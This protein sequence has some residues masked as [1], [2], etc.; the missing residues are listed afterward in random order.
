MIYG[1]P[2][3]DGSYCF[4]QAI[5]LVLANVVDIAAFSRR[6][7]SIPATPPQLSRAELVAVGGTWK[8]H[9]N[10]GEWAAIG[11]IPPVVDLDEFPNQR[12]LISGTTVGVK[13]SDGG[14][15]ERLM[16]A[17]FGLEPWNIMA[18]EAFFDKK[19]APGVTRPETAVL[20]SAQE[21]TDYRARVLAGSM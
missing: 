5:A 2:L 14:I 18:D 10:R 15:W 8:Q 16:A 3:P 12:L 13:H 20:L 4:V 19:L 6:V 7:N 17:W 21:R 1:M 11:M 9:L